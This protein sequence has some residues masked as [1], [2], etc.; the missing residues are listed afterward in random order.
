MDNIDP[1]TLK[2]LHTQFERV[3]KELSTTSTAVN[4]LTSEIDR[5]TRQHE[6]L[7]SEHHAL[8]N[9][10][11]H[12]DL[13]MSVLEETTRLQDKHNEEIHKDFR[14][15]ISAMSDSVKS[16]SVK[17]DDS[18][19]KNMK[20]IAG[21]HQE[22]RTHTKNEENWQK[23]I[24]LAAFVATGTGLLAVLAYFGRWIFIQTTGG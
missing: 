2:D 20:G 11:N 10:V 13:R 17:V 22:L 3:V 24:L 4:H 9:R 19:E 18:S 21:V 5:A 16:L 14:K 15:G 23:K 12:I 6:T 8:T 1:K 7:S